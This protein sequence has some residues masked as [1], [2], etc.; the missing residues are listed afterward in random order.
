MRTGVLTAA[1]VHRNVGSPLALAQADRTPCL[2]P[3]GDFPKGLAQS[4][5]RAPRRTAASLCAAAY[6]L[7]QDPR[8][9]P[10]LAQ[11]RKHLRAFRRPR[12]RSHD[13]RTTGVCRGNSAGQVTCGFAPLFCLNL[14]MAPDSRSSSP[15]FS[16]A[17][18]ARAEARRTRESVIL[19]EGRP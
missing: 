14:F 2:R 6:C 1:L 18:A 4:N 3:C 15:S 16:R 13:K 17:G 8:R 10:R 7:P 19:V 12:A 5:S 11:K 9:R